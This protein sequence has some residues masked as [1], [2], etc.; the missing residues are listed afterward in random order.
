MKTPTQPFKNLLVT[1][2]HGKRQAAISWE[3][4]PEFE[5]GS[6]FYI[7][8]SP[9]GVENSFKL[10]NPNQPVSG[11]F[12]VDQDFTHYDVH[13]P[14]YYG[15]GLIKA[16]KTY[17]SPVIGALDALTR[18]EQGIAIRMQQHE[19]RE[20][21][22]VDGYPVF[23]FIPKWRGKTALDFDHETGQPMTHM[24]SP[25][26]DGTGFG[27]RYEGGF[28][29]AVVTWVRPLQIDRK[30]ID[31]ENTGGFISQ[32]QTLFR[33]LGFPNVAPGHLIVNP[34]TDERY[35]VGLNVQPFKL[36]GK[37]PV[38]FEAPVE[39]LPRSHP[40]YQVPLPAARLNEA[41][42]PL[43]EQGRRIEYAEDD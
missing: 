20:M 39:K 27:L 13:Q 36:R 37:F 18:K 41:G 25:S 8:Y 23:Y 2:F 16:G 32:Q 35:E 5:Q 42:L 6:E 21:R 29:S 22:W 19:F 24:C 26:S 12:Y 33:F 4:K 3:V 30:V 40:Y 38:A 28:G 17:K 1:P 31:V 7:Y 10:L 34:N 14:G 43:D 15:V 11:M 9:T